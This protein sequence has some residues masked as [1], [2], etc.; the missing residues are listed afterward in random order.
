MLNLVL[1][2]YHDRKNTAMAKQ[3]EQEFIE[4]YG[5]AA[6]TVAEINLA[7]KTSPQIVIR[8]GNRTVILSLMALGDHLCI[9]VHPLIN[10]EDATASVFGMSDGK[11]WQLP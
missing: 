8:D 6:R 5:V 10:G 1:A 9:D 4:E 3:T 7:G 2:T 11:R